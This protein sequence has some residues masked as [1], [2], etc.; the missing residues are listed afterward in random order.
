M[1]ISPV[2][3]VQA[4]FVSAKEEENPI[5]TNSDVAPSRKS[6]LTS[7]NQSANIFSSILNALSTKVYCGISGIFVNSCEFKGTQVVNQNNSTTNQNNTNQVIFNRNENR[8]DVTEQVVSSNGSDGVSE[9]FVIDRLNELATIL[10]S[11]M[12]SSTIYVAGAQGPQG[13]QGVRGPSGSGSRGRAGE[14]GEDGEDAFVA[15]GPAGY[16]LQSTGTTTEWV[17][18][19]TLG[20][21]AGTPGTGTVS[22]I[23]MTVPTGLSVTGGPVTT[24]GTFAVS[25]TSGYVIPLTA[26]T[27]NWNT[28]FS[29]GDHST[30]GYLTSLDLN[31]I[32]PIVVGNGNSTTTLG[33]NAVIFG[34]NNTASA[35]SSLAVGYG[36]TASGWY[37]LATGYGSTASGV[38]SVASGYDN[39][40]TGQGS[41][42]S[43]YDNSA[44]GRNT[45]SVGSRNVSSAFGSTAV[46]FFNSAINNEGATAVGYNNFA[47]ATSSSAL[48]AEN[49]VY[50]I[51]SSA[52]GA[53]N[54][55]FLDRSVAV[56]YENSVMGGGALSAAFGINNSIS[57]TSGASIFGSDI[58]NNIASS[59]MVGPSNSAKVTILNTGEL[60]AQFINATSTTATSS[61]NGAVNIK[62]ALLANGAAGTSGYVLQ[63]TGTGVQWVATSSLG[64]STGSTI[65]VNDLDPIE[66]G[67]GN[68]A[69]GYQASAFG[70]LNTANES[71]TLAMGYQS[72]AAAQEA[73]AIGHTAQA[74]GFGSIS[75]GNQNAADVSN[76]AFGIYSIALGLGNSANGAQTITIGT[77]NEVIGSYS[78]ALGSN[79]T[80][81]GDY[82]T[83]IGNSNST[84]ANNASIFGSNITN[85]IASSTMIGPSD[86]A[87]VTIL[88]TGEVQANFFTATQSSAT[89]TF[90]G[91]VDLLGR[92]LANGDAGTNGYVLQTTGTGVQ[93][94]AT[95]SLGIT[96]GG[97]STDVNNLNPIEVGRG[98]IASGTDAI[99]F[100]YNS[101]A[102][103]ENSTAVGW[104]NQVDGQYAVAV[105]AG[106]QA[107][108]SFAVAMGISNLGSVESSVAVGFNNGAY[109]VQSVAMGNSNTVSGYMSSAIGKSNTSSGMYATALGYQN[110]ATGAESG[111][112]GLGNF[113]TASSSSAIGYANVASATSS[114]AVG[115][116]NLASGSESVAMG[117]F[118]YATGTN[119]VAV[120]QRNIN[121]TL[122]SVLFGL[123][124]YSQGNAFA[125]VALGILNN[126]SGATLNPVTGAITGTSAA[127]T[128][129]GRLT[130]AVG[131]SNVAVGNT[132]TAVGYKN[133][134]LAT[135][136]S[137][138]A[139][140]YINSVWGVS[141]VAVG[142]SNFSTGNRSISLG[143]SN[144]SEG[145]QSVAAGY[146]NYVTGYQA[147]GFGWATQVTATSATAIGNGIINNTANSLMIG[148]DNLAKITILSNA[149]G[150]FVGIGT[151]TPQGAFHIVGR[152]GTTSAL[153]VDSD[154]DSGD[155]AFKVRG[156]QS[157]G[158]ITDTNTR[159]IVMGSG[160]VGVGTSSPAAR[161]TV[162]G[163]TY[164][165]GALRDSSFAT[166]T[167]G[168]VLQSTGT[169]TRWVATSTLGISGGGST[170]LNALDPIEVGFGNVTSDLNT[171]AF[172]YQNTVS[173][174]YA[175]ASGYN[176]TASGTRAV[177]LGTGNTASAYYGS[178]VGVGNIAEEFSSAF[179][180]GN[181]VES[182]SSAAFGYQNTASVDSSFAFGYLNDASGGFASAFGHDNTASGYES[183]A[184][185]SGNTASASNSSAF[186][187]D[188]TNAIANSTM[189]GPS[190]SAKVTILSTGEFKA[191]FINATSTT[192]TSTFN[193]AVNI[194]S[195]L[196]ANG[197]PGTAG[198]ILQNTGSGVQWVSTSSVGIVGGGGG[199]TDVNALDPIEV[200]FG[201]TAA[202]YQASAFGFDSTASGYKSLAIGWSSEAEGIFATASGY[203][204]YAS[205][206][207]STASGYYNQ[208]TRFHASAFGSQNNATATSSSAIGRQN[209][210]SGISSNAFGMWNTANSLESVAMGYNNQA[211]ASNALAFGSNNLASASNSAVFGSGVTNNIASSVMIG[212]SQSAAA[213]ILST[214]EFKA[215]FFTA[216]STTAT[217]TFNGPVNIASRLLAN[218]SVGTAGYILQNTG[219]GVQ[220]VSTSSVGFVGGGGGSSQ[221]SDDGSNIFFNTGNV[222][223]GTA[224]PGYDLD[225]TGDVNITG[226]LYA[227]AD[228]G[229]LGQ[230]LQ[231]T[232]TG[233]QWVSTS[234]L[235]IGG[236]GAVDV[237]NLNPVE[238]GN[239]NSALGT[240]NSAIGWTNTTDGFGAQ[241]FGRGNNVE[242][243]F[244]MAY[245]NS[246][247]IT[248]PTDTGMAFG[249]GNT[250]T[251]NQSYIGGYLS[252]VNAQRSFAYGYSLTNNDDNSVMIGYDQSYIQIS[253]TTVGA[254]VRFNGYTAG[255]LSTNGSGV[256]TASSDE[257]LKDI[258]KEYDQSLEALRQINPIVY[259]WND[260]SGLADGL[261]YVGFSAQNIQSVIPEAVH[262]TRGG[263]LSLQDRPIMALTINAVKELDEK[264]GWM[265]EYMSKTASGM[266]GFFKELTVGK[267]NVE[268]EV[269]V[270]DVCVT[271]E[272]FKSL[273]QSNGGYVDDT[274]E[275]E[276]IIDIPDDASDTPDDQTGGGSG[277]PIGPQLP[278]DPTGGTTETGETTGDTEQSADD[279]GTS[280]TDESTQS[281]DSEESS[282]EGDSGTSGSESSDGD[283][284][285]TSG[286]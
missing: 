286:E 110:S 202:G 105:G 94:V 49:T 193:G 88:D 175:T 149:N 81:S 101:I 270:D 75:I 209:T 17:A 247:T 190:N 265:N 107:T 235:G 73:M 74:L 97:G 239:G 29:W 183:V 79:N 252:T 44:L 199:S 31:N 111:A 95:S 62:S 137:G 285:A 222:G 9:N 21:G 13:I 70:V 245:G 201:N 52:F 27:T 133:T 36:N 92:L 150:G 123:E 76:T 98:N 139:L 219:S 220:W 131:I 65:D 248:S 24:S 277:V 269:C 205:G 7:N 121:G 259:T 115:S 57:G 108:S 196:L 218:G 16:I 200:G 157:V 279:S 43:G 167:L 198:Y 22:S 275:E 254:S 204:N 144:S 268:G 160:N 42:A 28:A 61:F 67:N 192:A 174:N 282:T 163:D 258:E 56:G 253:T 124:N 173:G 87:K 113:A 91:G 194:K 6:I 82:T 125:S 151:T 184:F 257:R 208:A 69:S 237:N 238:V 126:Q 206:D 15:A 93:W 166:G 263:F 243:Q 251:S 83:M 260:E 37:S 181:T 165:S 147:M 221:W 212:P 132:G 35:T 195:A 130:T 143:I 187:N 186:G 171:S 170:D 225:V 8:T 19:T 51:E 240:Q 40:A 207:R 100:G 266:V 140:G 80:S 278:T 117:R 264:V 169:S 2:F 102:G 30:E 146:S 280:A 84:T 32:S 89:S 233:L 227:N 281:S 162:I 214:G 114:S 267:L 256:I 172:G 4:K 164:I 45:T 274:P 104:T 128:T 246:N 249:V 10:R 161:F 255:T 203:D 188:V 34:K 261:T 228:P 154:G 39:N 197:N 50:G 18:T 26:S 127:T 60:K 210:A 14:D 179:G 271:K 38:Y 55:V 180:Y 141:G 224:T 236:G 156:N 152:E 276:P 109:G 46:G 250:I 142:G 273:L 136:T 103:G 20:F 129:I 244:S 213:T 122:N 216:S 138:V 284:P 231:S 189:I 182:N 241:A 90:D 33:T 11:E 59:T 116:A 176:N 106:N 96:G 159:F 177:A 25:L 226:A 72:S 47:N 135:G 41:T 211:T 71:R 78:Y 217:S 99:A 85:A 242:G 230:L 77:T 54:I 234:T 229:T 145:S 64:F 272:Q 48:G 53:S 118:N 155:V 191:Q 153:T 120:G 168:Y 63:T 23:D 3:F 119:S 262:Q 148:A 158:L 86:S 12:N 215:P 1:I 232:A 134:V 68:T 185:G 5:D 223:I 283:T 178:A 66:V 58:T 112:I